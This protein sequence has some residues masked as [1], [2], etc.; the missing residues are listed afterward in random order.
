[1]QQNMLWDISLYHPRANSELATNCPL[2]PDPSPHNHS[3]GE[4]LGHWPCDMRAPGANL[5]KPESAAFLT[6]SSERGSA[7]WQTVAQELL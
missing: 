1:M 7:S 5:L 4:P 6:I 3:L 2:E